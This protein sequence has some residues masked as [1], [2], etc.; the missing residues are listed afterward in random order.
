[1]KIWALTTYNH[2]CFVSNGKNPP[3]KFCL[4]LQSAMNQPA[5]N[6]TPL[7]RFF[8]LENAALNQRMGHME[9]YI[10]ELEERMSHME[11]VISRLLRDNHYVNTATEAVMLDVISQNNLTDDLQRILDEWDDEWMADHAL[12]QLE[13]LDFLFDD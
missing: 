7:E 4:T 11:E 12:E 2:S 10:A 1:M 9:D 8:F 6:Y 13:D 3:A 5:A